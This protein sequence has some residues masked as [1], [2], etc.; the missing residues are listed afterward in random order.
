MNDHNLSESSVGLSLRSR[1]SLEDRD[2]WRIVNGCERVFA[3]CLFAAL[4]PVLLFSA[5]IVVVLSG[6]GPFIAHKRVGRCGSEIWVVKLRTM[7]D[8]RTGRNSNHAL[9]ERIADSAGAWPS[10]KACRDPRV[11]SSFAAFLR[12]YSIDELPQLWQVVCG[13]LAL[14]G[15][16]PI[17]R[18]EIDEYYGRDSATLLSRKP[19]ITGLWQVCGRS[20]LS[21]RQRRRL[22]L[23]MLQ[24]WSLPL[25]LLILARTIHRSPLG[26]DAW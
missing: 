2:F 18:R 1:T 5:L 9:F 3:F 20:R 14:V 19:G 8:R 12:R 7:W 6:R 15:P 10:V 24:K 11:A 25:Y 16:R 26:K 13:Q 4:L 21:Y 23:F 22:D 17:T